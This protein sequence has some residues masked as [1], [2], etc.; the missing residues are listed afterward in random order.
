M[1]NDKER[2]IEIISDVLDVDLSNDDL[3]KPMDEIGINSINFIKL[4]VKCEAL[5]DFEIEDDM[6]LISKFENLND[7]I[8]YITRGFL[9]EKE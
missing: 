7:F 9:D 4:V 6:L 3:S 8:D 5:L 2:L 1:I